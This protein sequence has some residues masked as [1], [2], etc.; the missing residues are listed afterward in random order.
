MI[1]INRRD[2]ALLSRRNVTLH[3]RDLFETCFAPRNSHCL[4]T[5]GGS[6]TRWLAMVGA[7]DPP[8]AFDPEQL[9]LIEQTYEAV[10]AELAARDLAKGEERK[11]VLRRA[12]FEAAHSDDID[13]D[14]LRERVLWSLARLGWET[15]IISVVRRR[16]RLA[17]RLTVN[18]SPSS[19]RSP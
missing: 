6:N 17:Q 4:A 12:M 5:G 3:G 14:K 16:S 10:C 13:P 8:R 1:L 7:F 9:D 19:L 15:S 18:K 11:Q 2:S